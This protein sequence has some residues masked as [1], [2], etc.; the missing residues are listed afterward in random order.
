ML[1]RELT[2]HLLNTKEYSKFHS[3]IIFF[4]ER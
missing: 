1:F 2:D 4:I 3:L